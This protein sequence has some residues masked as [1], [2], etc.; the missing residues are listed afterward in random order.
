MYLENPA[1]PATDLLPFIH[2]WYAL[3][4][5]ISILYCQS[6]NPLLPFPY[7][8]NWKHSLKFHSAH[9]SAHVGLAN[10]PTSY[11]EWP[12]ISPLNELQDSAVVL[13][14]QPQ[15]FWNAQIHQ[16]K[17]TAAVNDQVRARHS[18]TVLSRFWDQGK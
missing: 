3:K 7:G 8:M 18:P 6:H 16:S 17:P 5:S 11:W 14:S 10:L 15:E 2:L 4:F 1:L 12:C 13:L 9:T